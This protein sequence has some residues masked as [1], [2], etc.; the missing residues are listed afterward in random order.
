MHRVHELCQDAAYAAGL[1]RGREE[2]QVTI[3][4]GDAWYSKG[5]NDGLRKGL[6]KGRQE[7]EE[8][9]SA[10]GLGKQ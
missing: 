7:A 8:R 6:R 4:T 1:D 9:L 10:L 2:R 5:F 3:G